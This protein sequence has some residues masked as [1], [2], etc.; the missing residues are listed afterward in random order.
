MS[1][2]GPR[3]DYDA[4]LLV[5]FGGP[6][7]PDDVIPF[8]EN[9]TRGRGIPHERLVEVGAHYA[10]F[11]GVSPINAQNQAL[12]EAIRIDLDGAGLDLPVYWGNRNWGPYLADAIRA[13]RDD[14][15]RRA[16]CLVTSAYASYSGC[17]QYRE[18]LADAVAAVEADGQGA[19][20]QLD[21]I[22]HYFD[23]PGF[24]APMVDAV[25][26]SV[27]ELGVSQP[28]L[29][30]TT[31][32]IPTAS[33]DSSGPDGGAYVIQHRN[34]AGL[35]AAEVARRTSVETTWDLVF[36]SRSGAPQ[37]PW[38]EPDV[39]DHLADLAHRGCPGVVLV[40]IG[41]VSDHIEVVWDLDTVALRDARE[42]G[43]PAAR[44][45]TVGTDPRFVAMV[46]ELVLER[47]GLTPPRALSPIGPSYDVCPVGCCANPRGARPALCGSD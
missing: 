39:S 28:R 14:G 32:S 17:R 12:V 10:H 25:L 13:M 43:L 41:F 40:P 20:P 24:V 7:G 1:I 31:H 42:L 8:L 47:V 38:L 26:H 22:R 34:A 29:V 36:Q 9:V 44:A 45:A 18:N 27:A 23:H 16:L 19:A 3:G 2:S 4:L 21:K 46:R 6:E 5:S 30:F 11:G 15:V 35:V 33:A 37:V